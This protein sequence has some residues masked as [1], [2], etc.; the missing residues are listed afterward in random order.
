MLRD[1]SVDV[2]DGEVEREDVADDVVEELVVD[3]ED[4]VEVQGSDGEG[5]GGV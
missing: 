4:D 5:D 2:D 1:E 3:V